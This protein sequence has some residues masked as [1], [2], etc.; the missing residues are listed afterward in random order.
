GAP[1]PPCGILS[2]SSANQ[3]TRSVG[4]HTPTLLT[5]PPRLVLELTS[6]LTVTIRPPAW[7]AARLRSS[8]VRPSAAWVVPVPA[9]VRPRSPGMS[10]GWLTGAGGRA[11]RLAAAAHTA[12]S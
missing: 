9:G 11:R 4:D 5:Q 3:S 6:G 12:A 7:G 8:S 2:P 10:G 1:P